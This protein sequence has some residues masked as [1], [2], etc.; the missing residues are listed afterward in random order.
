MSNILVGGSQATAAADCNLAVGQTCPLPPYSLLT[1][2]RRLVFFCS[3]LPID[4]LQVRGICGRVRHQIHARP[5]R[6]DRM[7][8]SEMGHQPRQRLQPL[9]V[10]SFH[11]S[12]LWRIRLRHKDGL[13]ARLLGHIR[14]ARMLSTCHPVPLASEMAEK[15]CRS[16]HNMSTACNTPAIRC[17]S[18]SNAQP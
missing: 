3:L 11:Q 15:R 7:I 9:D 14:H 2:E 8:V 16:A 10:H 4:A 1:E 6:L 5:I 12:R 18:H 13:V 17:C